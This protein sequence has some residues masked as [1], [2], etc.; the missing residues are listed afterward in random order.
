MGRVVIFGGVE[1]GRENG[2]LDGLMLGMAS[3]MHMPSAQS[4]ERKSNWRELF[5]AILK[6]VQGNHEDQF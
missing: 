3:C 4:K 1:K 5:S 6:C 2:C